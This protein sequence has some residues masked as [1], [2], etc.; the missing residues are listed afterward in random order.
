VG[1]VLTDDG[2][3]ILASRFALLDPF[4]LAA[5]LWMV[6]PFNTM[7]PEFFALSRPTQKELDEARELQRKREI[8]KI[9]AIK[10]IQET[11]V[12]QKLHGRGVVS[13]SVEYADAIE[14]IRNIQP[15]KAIILTLETADLIKDEKAAQKMAYA[16]RRHL[17]AN[18]IAATAYSAKKNEVVIR[19]DPKGS[20]PKKRKG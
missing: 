18:S 14:A 4:Q 15:G 2:D 17:A 9:M 5:P 6:N 10:V 20:A 16:I 8:E 1:I 12:P 19:R 7:K 3:V 11:D 13:G